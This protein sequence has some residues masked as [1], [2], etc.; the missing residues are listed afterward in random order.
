M[1]AKKKAARKPARRAV[2]KAAPRK[3]SPIPE[4]YTS[5]TPGLVF[6]DARPALEWY[7]KAFGAKLTTRMDMPDGRIMHA[8]VRIGN[9]LLML[10]DEAPQMGV[11]SA[12]TLGGSSA[13]LMLY[14][15]DCDAVFA[16]AVALGAK[17]LVPL[18]D[19]F[20]GDRWG[21]VVDPFGHRWGIATHQRD[22]SPRQ[23][24]AAAAEAAKQMAAGQP[25]TA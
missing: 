14:V 7:Q 20:W 4:G 18:M 6:K 23:M 21:Q 25:P 5:L 19:M 2:R 11:P 3:V 15:K 9:A 16:K 12:E 22:L 1:A 17:P 10:G 24:A 8:E 13:G